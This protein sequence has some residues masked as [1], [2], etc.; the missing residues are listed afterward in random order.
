MVWVFVGDPREVEGRSGTTFKAMASLSAMMWV[1]YFTSLLE[2]YAGYTFI[3]TFGL[4]LSEDHGFSDVN[5]G[6]C[7]CCCCCFEFYCVACLCS[8]FI[9]LRFFRLVK[10]SLRNIWNNV[11]HFC[12]TCWIDG[13]VFKIQLSQSRFWL[14]LGFFVSYYNG[15]CS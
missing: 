10:A 1:V 8:T 2:Y 4:F 5:L 14:L 6:V 15:F 7:C 13:K 12:C 3:Y 9:N 11:C